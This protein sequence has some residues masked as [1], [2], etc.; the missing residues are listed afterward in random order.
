MSKPIIAKVFLHGCKDA[1]SDHASQLA[2]DLGYDQDGEETRKLFR[3]VYIRELELTL[4]ID[5]VT[6]EGKIVGFQRD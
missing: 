1:A 3:T 6:F 2:V 4:E 5:P